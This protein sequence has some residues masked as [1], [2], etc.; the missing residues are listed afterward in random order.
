[1]GPPTGPGEINDRGVLAQSLVQSSQG[2]GVSKW[3]L[4]P[5]GFG[6]LFGILYVYLSARH[7]YWVISI[8][9]LL[10]MRNS[11]ASPPYRRDRPFILCGRTFSSQNK[12]SLLT[13][14]T[15]YSVHLSE[16][17]PSNNTS[18]GRPV[19]VITFL[20]MLNIVAN[21]KWSVRL[22]K[23]I[24]RPPNHWR[25]MYVVTKVRVIMLIR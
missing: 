13:L 14:W 18:K 5:C 8:K 21:W 23:S 11:S 24:V 4:S 20:I 7:T 16:E 3:A 10:R 9:W 17:E 25:W 15:R 19:V 1:M 22:P 6:C 2:Q 12:H